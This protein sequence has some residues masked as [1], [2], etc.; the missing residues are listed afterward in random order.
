MRWMAVVAMVLALG[1]CTPYE[2][3]GVTLTCRAGKN[4]EIVWDKAWKWVGDNSNR[5][6]EYLD[7]HRILTTLPTDGNSAKLAYNITK[8]AISGDKY[9]IVFFAWCTNFIGCGEDPEKKAQ[10]FI[11]YM[12]H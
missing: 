10:Q 6:I 1:G 9:E 3:P 12:T 8:R 11:E 5:R 7:S 2:S 4:C